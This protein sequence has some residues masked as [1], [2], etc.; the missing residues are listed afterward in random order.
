MIMNLRMELFEALVATIYNPSYHPEENYRNIFVSI[1]YPEEMFFE[2]WV[3]V[4]ERYAANPWVAGLDL[5]NEIRRCE[6][7]RGRTKG[8]GL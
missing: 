1:Q 4:T 3:E 2:G 8:H 6:S 5:R 7:G